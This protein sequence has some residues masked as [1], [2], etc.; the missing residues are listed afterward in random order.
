M[1]LGFNNSPVNWN[2]DYGQLRSG[3]Y[4][5]N[6]LAN[7]GGILGN[8]IF[9]ATQ[10]MEKKRKEK[11]AYEA[12][13]GF[14]GEKYGMDED[15]AKGVVKG[16]GLDNFLRT[17]QIDLQQKELQQRAAEMERRAQAAEA[18]AKRAGQINNA[19]LGAFAKSTHPTSGPAAVLPAG[20]VTGQAPF[21]GGQFDQNMFL[22]DAITRGAPIGDAI[23]AATGISSL[24]PKKSFE[25]EVKTV[26]GVRMA[27]TSDG[28]YQVLTEPK[29]EKERETQLA[30]LV[31]E[32]DEYAKQGRTDVVQ[33]YNRAIQNY[34][35]QPD[36]WGNVP[37][38][39][40]PAQQADATKGS[41]KYKTAEDVIDEFRAGKIKAD[42]ARRI[43]KE[44]G[45]Q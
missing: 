12:A 19:L 35:V 42:E 21:A 14:L 28:Q 16:I 11:E 45:W 27:R 20:G 44:R 2:I 30:A 18:E 23:K 8:A 13:V 3:E 36:I 17:Q 38:A 39:Q 1:A 43:I 10:E 4:M 31:R 41:E 5:G 24:Q 25:P 34:G 37:G 9:K 22:R 40:A 33:Q 32:R 6:A 29:A 7:T 26:N 15:Q